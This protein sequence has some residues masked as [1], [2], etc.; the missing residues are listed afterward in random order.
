VPSRSISFPAV[1]LPPEAEELRNEVRDFLADELAG[2]GFETQCDSW[3]G[4]YST[5][6]SRRLGE[7]GWVGMT[8][9]R[10][11][12]GQARPA[13]DR[14]VVVEELLAAGAPVAAHWI[15]D[16][17]VGPM[18]VRYGTESQRRQFLPGI[19]RGELYFGIGMSEPDSGSDLAS[20]RTSAVRDGEG[21]RVTGA[22]VWTSHAHQSHFMVTLCRTSARGED[23]HEGLSQLIIDLKA[24]GVEVKP[25]RLVTGHDHFCEVVMDAVR[26]PDDMVIG[27]VG[28]GWRQVTSEL[29]FERSGPERF[30]ST[31]PLLAELVTALGATAGPAAAEAVGRLVARLHAL[32]R[33]SLGVAASI[34]AGGLPGTEAAL[35]KEMGTRFERE[36]TDAARLLVDAEHAPPTLRARLAEAV[37]H[38]PAFTLRGGTNEVLR[39]IVARGLSG[40]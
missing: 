11:Y 20:I 2:G 38:S 17:Q 34:D 10:E 29:A 22:K 21:W 9:P 19:A 3:L 23:R 31:F 33:L 24:P 40:R 18:L 37:L 13:L 16:R 12:G 35:V 36:V 6:F 15:T 27:E 25:I 30:L 5:A 28:Q 26:V 39:G 4:G 7:H 32:R 1:Q 8:L 14:F